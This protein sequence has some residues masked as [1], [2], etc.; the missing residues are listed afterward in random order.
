MESAEHLLLRAWS[1]EAL[2]VI[3]GL[4]RNGFILRFQVNGVCPEEFSVKIK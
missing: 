3:L 4:L 1:E 2:Q